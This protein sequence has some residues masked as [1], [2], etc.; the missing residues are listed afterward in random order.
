MTDQ[1]PFTPRPGAKS[2]RPFLAS[3][4][5]LLR[6]LARALSR[7]VERGNDRQ[8]ILRS[9]DDRT[10]LR[11]PVTLAVLLGLV[12]LWQATPFVIVAV[13]VALALKVQFIVA[14]EV[15]ESPPRAD[16]PVR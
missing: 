13:V 3:L 7:L 1:A 16:K 2:S 11:I 15:K 9:A 4:M 12:L 14:T 6:E 8:L 5:G 10:L